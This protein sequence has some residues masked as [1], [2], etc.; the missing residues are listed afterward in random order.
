MIATYSLINGNSQFPR[1]N[2]QLFLNCLQDKNLILIEN[3]LKKTK[4]KRKKYY[5]LQLRGT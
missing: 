4:I 5:E 2:L 1:L 3:T